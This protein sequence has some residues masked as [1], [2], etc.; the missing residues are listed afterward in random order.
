MANC[1][2]ATLLKQPRRTALEVSSPNQRSTKRLSRQNPQFGRSSNATPL[3]PFAAS[4]DRDRTVSYEPVPPVDFVLRTRCLCQTPVVAAH[5][6]G[7][8]S[9][10]DLS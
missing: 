7:V 1:R 2:S 3:D 4:C 9:T 5:R 6:R 8:T 10:S